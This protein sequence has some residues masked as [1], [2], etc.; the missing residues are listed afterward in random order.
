M[1]ILVKNMKKQGIMKYVMCALGYGTD[2]LVITPLSSLRHS[3]IITNSANYQ[4]TPMGSN[5]SSIPD[6]FYDFQQT[7][8]L[9]KG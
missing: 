9:S 5:P 7:D 1:R 4:G 8:N 2:L 3:V 6:G